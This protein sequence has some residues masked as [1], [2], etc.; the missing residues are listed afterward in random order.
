MLG[1]LLERNLV[2]PPLEFL[3]K[4]TFPASFPLVLPPCTKMSWAAVPICSQPLPAQFLLCQPCSCRKF[5]IPARSEAA[6]GCSSTSILL[7]FPGFPPQGALSVGK[8]GQKQVGS[9]STRHIPGSS[10]PRRD[11]PLELQH[12][13]AGFIPALPKFLLSQRMCCFLPV[14]QS[15]PPS[16]S[17]AGH[18]RA[19]PSASNP[20]WDLW[21]E[22]SLPSTSCFQ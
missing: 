4:N 6:A 8:W 3:F 21:G 16:C 5:L 13:R 10:P 14:V 19:L 17:Q 15:P 22:I 1:D 7:V 18:C 20:A 12:I 9:G 2:L 11:F